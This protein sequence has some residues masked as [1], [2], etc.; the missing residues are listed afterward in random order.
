VEYFFDRLVD[1]PFT[2]MS[3]TETTKMPST[4]RVVI[5]SLRMIAD[6]MIPKIGTRKWKAEACDAPINRMM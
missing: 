6:W 4:S 3:E 5:R 1:D 2:S